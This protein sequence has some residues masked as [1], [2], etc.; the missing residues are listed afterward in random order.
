MQVTPMSIFFQPDLSPELQTHGCS[1][2]PDSLSLDVR[3][4]LKLNM[5]ET[6]LLFFIPRSA[7]SMFPIPVNSTLGHLV[8]AVRKMGIILRSFLSL[9]PV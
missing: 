6:G 8:A 9:N 2:F 1:Y 3:Q 7:P 4:R 5:S